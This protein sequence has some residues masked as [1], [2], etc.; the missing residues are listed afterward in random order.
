MAKV[1][2]PTHP[3]SDVVVSGHPAAYRPV[4]IDGVCYK[5]DGTPADICAG[6]AACK[7]R[8]DREHNT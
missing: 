2:K 1:N 3:E 8:H 6:W 5:V 4:Q 7:K